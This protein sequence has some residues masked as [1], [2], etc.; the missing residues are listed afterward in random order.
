ME[1]LETPAMAV[2]TRGRERTSKEFAM[3]KH[4]ELNEGGLEAARRYARWHIGDSH[5]A[6]LILKAYFN[7]SETNAELDR[8]QA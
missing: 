3:T 1:L 5:W 7:P 2:T 6:D 8:E 4:I